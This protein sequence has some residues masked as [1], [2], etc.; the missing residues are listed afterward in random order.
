[1]IRR[2]TVLGMMPILPEDASG[3]E[4]RRRKKKKTLWQ[5]LWRRR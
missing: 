2:C 5:L 3:T 1:M 4:Q